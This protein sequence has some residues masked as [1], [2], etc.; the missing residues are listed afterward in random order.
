MKALACMAAM[1]ILITGCAQVHRE[2]APLK[3][4][5]RPANQLL[6]GEVQRDSITAVDVS[7]NPIPFLSAPH[8]LV[9]WCNDSGSLGIVPEDANEQGLSALSDPIDQAVNKF[10]F[11]WQL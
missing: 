6:P 8:R 4:V 1:A 10:G 7:T 9:A 2:T 5:D 3:C 11:G